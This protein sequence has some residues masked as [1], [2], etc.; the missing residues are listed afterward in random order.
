MRVLNLIQCAALGGMETSSLRLMRGLQARGHRVELMSLHP[1]GDLGPL[2]EEAG[3]AARGLNYRGVGGWRSLPLVRAAIARSPHDALLM[4]GHNLMASLA[5]PAKGRRRRVLAMHYPH[6]GVMRDWHWRLLYRV[7]M[8]RFDS[9]TYP[10]DFVREE[11]LRLLPA[12]GRIART[13]RNPLDLPPV[14]TPMARRRARRDFGLPEGAWVIGNAGHLIQ[15]KRFDVLLDVAARLIGEVPECR[16][17]IAGDGELRSRLEAQTHRLGIAERV[18]WVGRIADMSKFYE[19][20]DLLLFN[21]DWDAYPTTPLEAMAH[22]VPVVASSLYG[23]LA[24]V[25]T[26]REHGVLL[27]SH[28]ADALAQAALECRAA[29]GS[30]PGRCA[31]ERVAELGAEASTVGLVEQLLS[32]GSGDAC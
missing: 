31:R 20:L 28:D 1:I 13:V 12:L 16:V 29:K 2:L 18:T 5:L 19:A 10:S 15:H 7:V 23:G 8:A 3:I 24:E 9:I 6:R 14:T 11:A 27:D 26:G 21:S 22:G 30:R 17:L 32:G 25:I 4:T